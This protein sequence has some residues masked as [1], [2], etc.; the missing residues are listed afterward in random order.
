MI[1]YSTVDN[2]SKPL[3]PIFDHCTLVSLNILL[4]S[5]LRGQPGWSADR[6]IQ[7]WRHCS[8]SLQYKILQSQL[9]LKFR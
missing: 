4:F 7:S 5:H 9:K 6:L 3:V 8:D 2:Q 1:H